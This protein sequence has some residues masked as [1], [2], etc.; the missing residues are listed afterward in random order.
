[1]PVQAPVERLRQHIRD[2][3]YARVDDRRAAGVLAAFAAGDQGAIERDNWDLSATPVA[4]VRSISGLHVTLFAWLAGLLVAMAQRRHRAR[5]GVGARRAAGA[6]RKRRRHR[7]APRQQDVVERG[8][9]QRCVARVA[10]FQAGDRDR[11]GHP[12]RDGRAL[13]RARRAAPASGTAD[14]PEDGSYG[15]ETARRS[16]HHPLD[17]ETP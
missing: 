5:A 13:P 3:I 6:A 4:H 12:G 1:M 16:W 15:R 8:V 11:F 10:V 9:P 7:A 2:A 14:G 17:E